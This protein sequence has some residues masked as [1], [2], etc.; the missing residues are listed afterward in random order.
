M[1]VWVLKIKT[2]LRLSQS[3]RHD[4]EGGAEKLVL[5]QF[6]VMSMLHANS[7]VVLSAFF[8]QNNAKGGFPKLVFVFVPKMVPYK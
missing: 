6:Y 5:L 8:V 3:M 4:G 1:G 2:R 7:N